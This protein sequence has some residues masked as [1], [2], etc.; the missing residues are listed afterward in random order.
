MFLDST[1][2]WDHTVLSFSVWL[3]SFSTLPSRSIHVVA[4]GRIFF[5]F[6]GD[7]IICIYITFSIICIPLYVCSII[8]RYIYHIFF[9]H[10]S[11]DGHVCCFHVF[12]IINSAAMNV[13]VQ[14]SFW[15]HDFISF[16]GIAG[17]YSSSIFNVLR[18]LHTVF[19]NGCTS[20]HSPQ[21]STFSASSPAFV[22][23]YFFDNSHSNRFDV[24]SQCGFHQQW[25]FKIYVCS[26]LVSFLTSTFVF[27]VRDYPHCVQSGTT[28][29]PLPHLLGPPTHPLEKLGSYC[30]QL[31][32]PTLHM[33]PASASRR[34]AFTIALQPI[35]LAALL[36]AWPLLSEDCSSPTSALYLL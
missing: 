13:G 19:H 22:I 23:S 3:I 34:L 17:S 15:D 6:Y 35:L 18:N 4:N 33:Q 24:L 1:Y 28:H 26:S 9:I 8:C 36:R 25:L 21:Q 20:L 32:D 16:S 27:S 30:L 14:I 11:V 10:S 5:F 7:S 12:T 31:R 29:F 2:K